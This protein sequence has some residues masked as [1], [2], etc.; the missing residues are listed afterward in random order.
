MNK[1]MTATV[2]IANLAKLEGWH[3]SGDGADV[4]IEKTYKF[5]DYAHTMAFVNAVAWGAQT[6][7]HHPELHVHFNRCVVRFQTHD[8]S[9]L[10]KA[11][12]ESA[13]AV[14]SLP[15]FVLPERA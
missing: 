15:V 10:S 1:A 14:D 6:R 4:A 3:L 2:V 5:S 9:G 12:F 11:D 7:N 13:A 8:V